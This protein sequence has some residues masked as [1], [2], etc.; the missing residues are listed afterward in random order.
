MSPSKLSRAFTLTELLIVVSIIAILASIMAPSLGNAKRMAQS[1]ACMANLLSLAKS[2][3][4]YHADNDEQFWQC[5]MPNYPRA[6]VN[7]YFWGTNTIPVETDTFRVY[8][9]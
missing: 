1:A 8:I 3:G 2:M 6:G 9:S 5:T 4:Q 7:T